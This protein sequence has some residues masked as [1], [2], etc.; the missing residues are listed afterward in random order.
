MHLMFIS[1]YCAGLL[2]FNVKFIRE[3]CQLNQDYFGVLNFINI[4]IAPV[5]YLIN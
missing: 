2:L 3:Y 1:S 4:Q 5:G